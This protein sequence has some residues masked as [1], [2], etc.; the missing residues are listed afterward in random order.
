MG[1]ESSL[2]T[3]LHKMRPTLNNGDYVFCVVDNL[4]AIHSKDII[5]SFREAEGLTIIISK[6]LDGKLQLPYTVVLAWIML[7]V[8]SFLEAVEL[9]ASFSNVEAPVKLTTS[10]RSN[11]TTS[12]ADEY[13]RM[14]LHM[15]ININ[16]FYSGLHCSNLIG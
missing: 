12:F 2:T 9:T 7:T 1:G 11:L 10:G 6:E 16:I 15:V 8:H 4:D 14:H 13:C 3:L 5:G